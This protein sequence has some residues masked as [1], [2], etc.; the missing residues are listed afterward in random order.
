M[1]L[2]NSN[3]SSPINLGNPEEFSII[4]LA[5]LVKLKINKDLS[6]IKNLYLKMILPKENLLLI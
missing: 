5:R 4:K 2:M 6:L 1:N 3:Y